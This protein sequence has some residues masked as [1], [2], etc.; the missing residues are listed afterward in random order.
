MPAPEVAQTLTAL[1]NA[2]TDA[3]RAAV[4]ELEMVAESY[5][6]EPASST[7][8]GPASAEAGVTAQL[9]PEARQT[10][11]AIAKEAAATAAEES[12]QQ[13]AAKLD[14]AESHESQF[15]VQRNEDKRNEDRR[16]EDGQHE[17]RKQEEPSATAASTSPSFVN[18]TPTE[19][20]AANEDSS[21]T[22]KIG[23]KE[24]DTA[25][26]TAAAW[27]NWRRV[28]ESGHP[29]PASDAPSQQSET[30]LP[31]D[32]AAM[33]VAAGAEKAPEEASAESESDPAAIASIVDSVLADLRPR[34]FE[35][36]SRKMGKKK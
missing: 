19:R 26:T 25:T 28:R 29:K 5:V 20:T 10:L 27:A 21:S 15:E 6:G 2:S 8:L 12:K 35:E 11:E 36:I 14:T 13:E 33:A 9:T 32:A 17:A 22:G 31:K 3:L 24:P 1:A 18:E 23:D 16:N 34:I 7:L 30:S 4:Q